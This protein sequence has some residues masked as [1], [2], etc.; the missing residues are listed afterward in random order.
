MFGAFDP[1]GSFVAIAEGMRFRHRTRNGR[2]TLPVM[3]PRAA[4]HCRLR[5]FSVVDTFTDEWLVFKTD[6]SLPSRRVTR[7][8]QRIVEQRGTPQ[9]LRSGYGARGLQST[10]SGRRRIAQSAPFVFNP[11]NRHRTGISKAFTGAYEMNVFHESAV[12]CQPAFLMLW[13][14]QSIALPA[15][16]RLPASQRPPR[17]HPQSSLDT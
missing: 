4:S 16:P 5:V 7:A 10:L 6:T 1:R 12:L 13:R 11:R 3:R 17:F 8:L 9:F 14:F 15:F 2:L